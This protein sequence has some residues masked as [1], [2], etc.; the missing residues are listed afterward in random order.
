[1]QPLEGGITN[2]NILVDDGVAKFVARLGEDI[3]EHGVM[4]WHELSASQAAHAAGVSPRV[5]YSQHGVL[6]LEYIQSTSLIETDLHDPGVLTSVVEL[7]K[8]AHGE[9]ALH[10]RGNVLSFWIF[11][12]LRD[13]AGT[14]RDRNSSH[15]SKL[16]QLLD[17]A[18]IL[19]KA[20]GPVELV[21]GHNDLLPANIL[22]AGDRYWLIDWEYAG[23]NSPLFDL[24]GLAS[25]CAL[26]REAETRM[27]Q[28]YYGTAPDHELWHRYDAMKCASLLR[29]TMWSMVSEITSKIDFEY[30]EYTQKNLERYQDAVT[31]FLDVRSRG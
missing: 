31:L 16:D 9:V 10:M 15:V 4:R 8:K 18:N 24:G 28:C 27:L 26:D 22:D 2:H 23:F 12:I 13:Y 6:V 1:V 7:V 11:H 17:Q 14:L 3:P 20:V 25:N 19:E 21:F 29:E 5:H 30:S